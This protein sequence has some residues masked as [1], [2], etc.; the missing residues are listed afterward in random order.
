MAVYVFCSPHMWTAYIQH[1]NNNCWNIANLANNS[2]MNLYA[3]I[4]RDLR[5]ALI[6]A[7]YTLHIALLTSL[8]K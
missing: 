6:Q 4:S 3:H 2:V 5:V 1:R 8:H 7:T